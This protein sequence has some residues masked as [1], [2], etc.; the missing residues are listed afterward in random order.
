MCRNFSVDDVT[1]STDSGDSDDGDVPLKSSSS[2]IYFV[3]N[4]EVFSIYRCILHPG[5]STV[6][7][8]VFGRPLDC[9]IF[10]LAGG[11][12]AAGVFAADKMIAHKAF[13]RYVVRA[14][15][16]SVQ[17]VNDRSKGAAHSAGAKLR[18]YNER[19][20]REDIVTVLTSWSVHL[21]N[22]PLVFIRCAS[23][24]RVIFHEIDEGG[25]NRKDPRLRTI[26]FETK[27]PLVDEV[28][29][30]WERLSSVFRHGT[31]NDFMAERRRR[32][33]R[34]KYLLE[35]GCN[36]SIKNE[37]DMVAYAVSA[38]KAIKKVFIQFRSENPNKW[39]WARCHIPEPTQ[40]TDEQI[41]KMTE[42]KKEKKQ[43]QKDRS[44]MKKE[45][46]RKEAE[47]MVRGVSWVI[48][49]KLSKFCKRSRDI[50]HYVFNRMKFIHS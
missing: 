46:E 47:E 11:H 7:V 1:S 31:V 13:H 22:T 44:K 4:D 8:A 26:P 34:V 9:A 49:F 30:V 20:L 10:L 24:Q 29:R 42:K 50:E 41:A 3:H 5:E 39:N 40:I 17:S 18:R 45:A 28:R 38:N 36:P 43:R 6:S 14:K 12:F 19:A 25:F 15:Q 37:N 32:K 16:G 21:A 33:Q 2:H 48:L 23:Y 27:R 35:V